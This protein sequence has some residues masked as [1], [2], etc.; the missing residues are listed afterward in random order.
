MKTILMKFSGPLQSWGTNSHYE[1]RQTNR[2]PSKSA[3]IGMIAAAMGY[4]RDE[5]EKLKKL[6]TLSF[7]VRVDQPGNI[8]SDFQIATSYKPNGT[9]NRNYVTNR[10]YLQDAVFVVAIGSEDEK[11]ISEINKR[12]ESPYFQIYLGR[13][14]CPIN[15]DYLI[16]NHKI[17]EQGLIENLEKIPWQAA[18]W[19][20]RR[21]INQE[22]NPLYIC[23]DS[24]LL[25][26]EY[27]QMIRDSPQSFAQGKTSSSYNTSDRREYELRSVGYID[28]IDINAII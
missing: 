21:C 23:A 14:S 28:N 27:Y 26:N 18:K 17:E 16:D 25:D 5:N 3:V 1:N 13:K 2:F 6:R 7:G 11:L 12:L 10:Y 19:Y 20:Q 15:N 9:K 8:L 22:L 4:R 24:N